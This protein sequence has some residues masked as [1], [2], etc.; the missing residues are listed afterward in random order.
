VEH[1]FPKHL[2]LLLGT[3]CTGRASSS[4]G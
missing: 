3:R 2:M 1:T 4:T